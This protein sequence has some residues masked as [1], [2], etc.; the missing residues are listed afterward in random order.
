MSTL[1]KSH[2]ELISDLK[3]FIKSKSHK[4]GGLTHH[5]YVL[6]AAFRGKDIRKT[7]HQADGENALACLKEMIDAQH[8]CFMRQPTFCSIKTKDGKPLFTM[9]DFDFIRLSLINAQYQNR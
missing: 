8:T 9:K 5:H 7:S 2:P 4:G 3:T 6:Y 1:S